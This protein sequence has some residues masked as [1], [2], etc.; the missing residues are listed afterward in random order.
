MQLKPG[1]TF[2]LSPLLL[3]KPG[4]KHFSKE[5]NLDFQPR[6]IKTEIRSARAHKG[7]QSVN[8]IRL[9]WCCDAAPACI[10][11]F[12]PKPARPWALDRALSLGSDQARLMIIHLKR[13]KFGIKYSLKRLFWGQN[14]AFKNFP[15]EKYDQTAVNVNSQ[16]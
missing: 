15:I 13:P 7:R 5:Q 8:P 9:F 3:I 2:R 11:F 14:T 6:G 4:C 1:K 16:N 12:P 10:E